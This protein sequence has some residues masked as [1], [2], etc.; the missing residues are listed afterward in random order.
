[1]VQVQGRAV[2]PEEDPDK[3]ARVEGPAADR[4]ADRDKAVDSARV[5]DPA[6][7]PDKVVVVVTDVADVGREKA[8]ADVDTGITAADVIGMADHGGRR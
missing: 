2:D 5:V 3:V 8:E 1:M 6:E 4:V 7:G